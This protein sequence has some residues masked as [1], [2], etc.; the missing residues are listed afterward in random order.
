MDLVPHTRRL[1]KICLLVTLTAWADAASFADSPLV[2]FDM[3]GSVVAIET[4]LPGGA[5]NREVTFD[6][7]LSSLVMDSGRSTPPISQLLVQVRLRDRSPVAD[8]SPKTELQTE[9]AGPIAITNKTEASDTFGLNVDGNLQHQL[10]GHIGGEETEKRSDSTQFERHAPLQAVIASGTIDRAR[11]VYFK[12]RWTSQSVLEGEKHF[13][14]SFAVPQ[15]WRGGLIDVHV[16][17]HGPNRNRFSSQPL[18]TRVTQNFVIAAYQPNDP[19]AAELALRLAT[20]DRKLSRYAAE[21]ADDKTHSIVRF[22]KRV[23]DLSSDQQSAA[24]DWYHRIT[25]SFHNTAA[26][27]YVD[28]QIQSLPMPVRVAVLDYTDTSRQLADLGDAG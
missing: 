12:M 24:R 22:W 7:P 27:P 3:P 19:E 26:D 20:L 14:V 9:F 11:G 2:Q 25:D 5:H 23:F 16:S 1:L 15:R 28:K 13:R 17:A 10:R 21:H 18:E 6:L 4:S 8:F